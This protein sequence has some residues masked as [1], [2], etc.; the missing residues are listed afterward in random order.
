MIKPICKLL[1][2]YGFVM[3][4]NGGSHWGRFSQW[5]EVSVEF[6]LFI[7]VELEAVS[8]CVGTGYTLSHLWQLFQ[9]VGRS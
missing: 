3:N 4:F 6:S 5:I 7:V 9:G 8:V 1:Y 2:R